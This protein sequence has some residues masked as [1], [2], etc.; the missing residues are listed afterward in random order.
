MR[1]AAASGRHGVL[2]T[3]DVAFLH[4]VGGLL[5]AR[6]HALSATIVVLDDDG[7]AIFSYLPI[8]AHGE[9][10]HFEALFRTP[11]GVDLADAAP[12][13]GAHYERVSCADGFRGGLAAS[14]ERGGL[15]ILAVAPTSAYRPGARFVNTT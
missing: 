13:A 7:G 3:G 11:H 9:V 10:V 1:A 8:A 4:D 12:L 6:R 15:T 2:L 5:A 14:F